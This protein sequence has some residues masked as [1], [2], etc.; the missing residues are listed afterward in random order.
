MTDG[1]GIK[2]VPDYLQGQRC[3]DCKS[4]LLAWP[5]Q[6]QPTI[7]IRLE[8]VEEHYHKVIKC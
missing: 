1:S 7:A 8:T 6:A 4:T 2:I 5:K 3:P